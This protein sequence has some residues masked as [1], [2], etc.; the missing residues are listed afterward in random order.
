MVIPRLPHC[1]TPSTA[2]SARRWR[3]VRRARDRTLP[4]R[5]QRRCGERQ[6]Y[7]IE[8]ELSV[9]RIAASG[10]P[11]PRRSHC[12]RRWRLGDRARLSTPD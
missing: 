8:G 3:A 6:N 7:H 11:V 1:G 4:Y 2:A 5:R 9:Q 10:Q 12:R